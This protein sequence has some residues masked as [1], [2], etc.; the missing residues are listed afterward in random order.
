MSEKKCKWKKKALNAFFTRSVHGSSICP[1]SASSFIY[2]VCISI[3]CCATQTYRVT[4][5]SVTCFRASV[6]PIVTRHK[7]Q[8]YCFI[9]PLR[10]SR[11]NLSKNFV[12]FYLKVCYSIHC[13]YYFFHLA[14]LW[15]LAII[16]L[17]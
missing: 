8:I 3:K 2:E 14:T 17:L 12:L 7:C 9:L 4:R 10:I 13:G 11:K 16:S 15:C 1:C 5:T 6:R